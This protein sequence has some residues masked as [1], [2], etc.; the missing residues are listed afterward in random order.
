MSEERRLPCAASLQSR[1]FDAAAFDAAYAAGA[2]RLA[3]PDRRPG[4]RRGGDRRDPHPRPAAARVRQ[5]DPRR[6]RGRTRRGAGG[7]RVAAHGTGDVRDGRAPAPAARALPR[8]SR[9]VARVPGDL[10]RALRLGRPDDG[11]LGAR[12]RVPAL[13]RPAQAG[14]RAR[15]RA[16]A[17]RRSSPR[18]S[19]TSRPTRRFGC[20]C[21]RRSTSS[22]AS[23]PTTWPR[24]WPS[25]SR[26]VRRSAAAE[27]CAVRSAAPRRG[28]DRPPLRAACAPRPRRSWAAR[29]RCGRA[30]RC[31]LRE[32]VRLV[33]ITG[34]GG[35][36][37]SR[38][39]ARGGAPARAL[40]PRRRGA[41]AAGRGARAGAGASRASPAGSASGSTSAKPSIDVVAESLAE[42]GDACCCSTTPS[43]C[44]TP[45]TT[46][47]PSSAP[48]PLLTL[49]VTSRSR[50]RLVAEHDLP[51]QPLDVGPL[52]PA[53]ESSARPTTTPSERGRGWRETIC[54]RAA[55][56]RP[57]ARLATW[58]R[59]GRRPAC[60]CTPSCELCRR[61]DGL[62]L[63]IELA[64][65]RVRLL[66]PT[67]LLERLDRRLDLPGVAPRRPARAPAHPALDARLEPRAALAAVRARPVRAALDLRRR[68]VADRDRG[69]RGDRRRRARGARDAGRPQPARRR[70]L[71]ARR[72]RGSPCSRPCATTRASGSRSRADDE[73]GRLAHRA[74]VR[75]IAATA[76][77]A[78]AGA[79][80][81][82]W[83]ERLELESGNI[84]A[85]G[86]R[87]LRRR[88]PGD[89]GRDRLQHVAV[90]VGPPPHA[91]GEAV[92][93]ARARVRRPRSTTSPARGSCGRSPA[94]RSSRATTTWRSRA[95]A[96]AT[97]LFTAL[98]DAEGIALCGFLE[99]SLAPLDDDRDR[100]VAVFTGS[101][102]RCSRLGNVFIAS[103]C[104][105]TAGHGPRA[106]GT[107]RRG[108]GLPRPA[109]RCRPTSIDSAMLRAAA[110]VARGFARLGRGRARRVAA[111]TSRSARAGRTHQE[112]RVAVV[113]LRRPRRRAARTRCGRRGGGA[114]LVGAAQGLRER[115]GIVPWPGLRPVMAA[116]ADGVRAERRRRRPTTRA[117]R[118]GRHL[119]VDA[120]LELTRSVGG[121]LDAVA[122]APTPTRAG[123]AGSEAG[124]GG[125]SAAAGA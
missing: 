116:I 95:L 12:G 100:A 17:R 94:P 42:R 45:P 85:A 120:I 22:P 24:C 53:Y 18:C 29:P 87:A 84:R 35:I 91:R 11:H 119:S 38:R 83:L 59:P 56:P 4:C 2:A 54:R 89:A 60:S 50:M 6:A 76:R 103:I 26:R 122:A 71:G 16:R 15:A 64:A 8:V 74:W 78:L 30:R 36:G 80:H 33:T 55:V 48:A 77:T 37:K 10:R 102:R 106:A 117:A 110:F 82:D 66:P 46:S 65:A 1:A 41:R 32:D 5:L 61:L 62:P 49:L 25:R 109:S 9:A 93:R 69:G 99:A 88:R 121:G 97:E 81:A 107:V 39:G 90:A 123:A 72:A 96:E 40:L 70:R 73:V 21:A 63:A 104:S 3:R 68:R 58:P 114:V 28:G 43:R 47:P 115:V 101:R 98:G 31:V 20:G 7:R 125:G 27:A 111:A 112:P 34:M 51:L 124:T 118:R 23:S 13:R 75:R 67:Q 113:R 14:L 79:A 86:S 105:S 108:R 92:A 44:A 57:R 19:R 52:A